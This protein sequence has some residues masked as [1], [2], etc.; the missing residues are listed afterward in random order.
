MQPKTFGAAIQGMV[1]AGLLMLV[2]CGGSSAT[3]PE[4]SQTVTPVSPISVSI[5]VPSSVLVDTSV[6]L[7]AQVQGAANPAVNWTVND[8]LNGNASVGIISV[9]A[10]QVTYTAPSS[11]GSYVVAAVSVSDPSKSGRAHVKVLPRARIT[12]VV[13][14]PSTYSMEAGA[15][16]QFTATV[17]GTETFNTA[18]TWSAQRGSISGTGLYL[19]PATGGSD[20]V[21]ATSVQD[22][23]KSASC[24]V[25][26]VASTSVVSVVVGPTTWGLNAGAQKQFA[27]TVSGSGAFNPGVTWSAQR[28]SITSTGLYTAPATAGTDVVTATSIQNISRTGTASLTVA[29]S[30]TITSVILTPASTTL[31]ASAQCQFNPTVSGTGGFNGAVT[32]SAQRGTV[33]SSGLYTAPATGGTDVVTA[34]SVQ[35]TSK[36]A[37]ASVTVSSPTPVTPTVTAVAISPT[38]WSLTAGT[39]KQFTA[40]VSGTG[41]YSSSVIWSALHGSVDNSGLYTAP[42]SGSDVVTATSSADGSK[43]GSAAILVQSGCAPSPTAA[44]VVNARDAAYGAKGDGVTDDTAAIQKAVNAVAGTGGTVSI[45]DGTY[46]INAVASSTMGIRL[47]SNMTLS[48]SSGAVLKAIPTS[49]GTYAI[50]AARSVSNVNIVGGTLLGERSAHSGSGGEWGM[51]LSI[52]NSSHV[53]V[54]GVTAKDCWGDGFYITDSSSDVTLCNLVGDHNRRQGLS[55]TSVDGLVVRNC[56]F[57]NTTG[58]E[59]ECGIDLEPNDGQIIN[60]VSITGCTL[61][62][63]AGGGLSAG[64]NTNFTTPRITNTV[65]DGCI[66]DGNGVN[67]VTG[68]YRRGVLV[69]HSFGNITI[70]NCQIRNTIGQGIMVMEGSANTTLTGNTITGTKLFNGNTTWT[71]GGIYI[72][73]SPHSV[74]TSNTVT[75]NEGLGIWNCS[76]DA[77]IQISGNTVSGNGKP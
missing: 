24:Q 2:A 33:S 77:S 9:I 34:K 41:S 70:S 8:V 62:N 52:S 32:W 75:G 7:K 69:G 67:P 44:L 31:N 72:S 43:S 22:G 49:S 61:T 65:V 29:G 10:D 28:G 26:L 58:T 68:G 15:Q 25:T 47:G 74:I 38:S 46:M 50:L 40:T 42:A 36:S 14:D 55:V 39:R 35:D 59:P 57:K 17:A 76:S 12:S 60:N 21:T 71:G 23:G 6:S 73:E 11:E 45:P 4:P 54:Q 37:T 64:F 5:D 66:I 16:K 48:L 53:V 18:V 1:V 51:G 19:A 3:K 30:S 63:N 56:V 20:V 13:V 27:A